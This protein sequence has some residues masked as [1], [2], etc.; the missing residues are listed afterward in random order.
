MNIS[1]ALSPVR[2]AWLSVATSQADR[3]VRLSDYFT[4]EL[5]KA[6]SSSQLK[7]LETQ[8]GT[9]LSA[10]IR[11][12]RGVTPAACR[13][14]I[15]KRFH[16]SGIP[17]TVDERRCDGASTRFLVVNPQISLAG[18]MLWPSALPATGLIFNCT[19]V[20][21]RALAMLPAAA[22]QQFC[23]RASVPQ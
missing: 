11:V 4:G 3:D 15:T 17:G 16:V 21:V 12:L 20:L 10:A 18:S 7:L 19:W 23:L 8:N 22:A 5:C 9:R 1:R 13:R 14:K 6:S 2:W